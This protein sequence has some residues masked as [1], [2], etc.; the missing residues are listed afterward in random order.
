MAEDFWG[1]FARE[2]S[3]SLHFQN[4]RLG[5]TVGTVHSRPDSITIL[6][7]LWCLFAID[8]NDLSA[9]LSEVNAD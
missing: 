8:P 6:Y 9:R 3:T 5:A 4:L 2:L 1:G 7:S